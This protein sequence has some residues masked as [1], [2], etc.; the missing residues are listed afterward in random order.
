MENRYSLYGNI[1]EGAYQGASPSC[2]AF[3]GCACSCGFCLNVLGD[4]SEASDASELVKTLIES[5]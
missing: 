3:C 5:E 4:N 2:A 1:K